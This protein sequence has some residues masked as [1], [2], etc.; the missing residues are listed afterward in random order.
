MGQ[1]IGRAFPLLPLPVER[2]RALRDRLAAT[3][4]GDVPTVLAR[5]WNDVLDDIDRALAAREAS[6]A[7]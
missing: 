2:R 3:L 1:L 6:A 4:E 7:R 5:A